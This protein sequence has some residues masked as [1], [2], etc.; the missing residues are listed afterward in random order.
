MKTE[1]KYGLITGIGLSIYVFVEYLLGFHTIY[2]DIGEYSGYFSAIIPV[3]AIFFSIKEKRNRSFNGIISFGQAFIT[4]LV[5][6]V[7]SAFILT[8]FFYFYNNNINP[9]GINYLVEWKANQMREENYSEEE[10]VATIEEYN[11]RNNPMVIFAGT[12]G[13]GTL[14]TII[15]SFLLRRNTIPAAKGEV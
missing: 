3:A 12:L 9:E 11:V 10:I 2:P 6:S 7:I 1:L 15:F 8:A 14:I 5:I 13:M 4:G